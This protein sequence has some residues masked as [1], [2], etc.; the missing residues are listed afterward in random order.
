MLKKA[1]QKELL[2]QTEQR[3]EEY[4]KKLPKYKD[5]QREIKDHLSD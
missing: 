2:D 1:E 5:I 3:L 4:T